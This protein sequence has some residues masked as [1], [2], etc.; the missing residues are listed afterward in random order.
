MTTIEKISLDDLEPISQVEEKIVVKV[1]RKWKD[2]SYNN[3]GQQGGVNMILIDEFIFHFTTLGNID[4]MGVEDNYCIDV[5]GIIH[6]VKALEVKTNWKNEEEAILDLV[7]TDTIRKV[8]IHFR[9]DFAVTCN[10]ALSNAALQPLQPVII[11]L[12]S[13]IVIHKSNATETCLTNGP[14]TDIFINPNNIRMQ[15]L[16]NRFFCLQGL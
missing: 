10:V 15:N 1:S 5:V 11:I 13:C 6:S 8:N 9:G 3:N 2:Y 7:I 12:S 4:D 14:E 16:R